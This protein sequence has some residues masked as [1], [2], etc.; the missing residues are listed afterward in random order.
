MAVAPLKGPHATLRSDLWPPLPIFRYNNI[1]SELAECNQVRS[2]IDCALRGLTDRDSSS[3]G[4]TWATR[5][6]DGLVVGFVAEIEQRMSSMPVSVVPSWQLLGVP[7]K[8]PPSSA[9]NLADGAVSA[10]ART[11]GG[12][13]RS[14]SK[15]RTRPTFR[16]RRVHELGQGITLS[17]QNIESIVSRA[18]GYGKLPV[19]VAAAHNETRKRLQRMANKIV[20][21]KQWVGALATSFKMG[22]KSGDQFRADLDQQMS[23][24]CKLASDLSTLKQQIALCGGRHNDLSALEARGGAMSL[25]ATT[26]SSLLEQEIERLKGSIVRHKAAASA[27]RAH[28]I[29][30]ITA[31]AMTQQRPRGEPVN[32][33][34]GRK[35]MQVADRDSEKLRQVVVRKRAAQ[36]TELN[37]LQVTS[38]PGAEV[39][40]PVEGYSK[41]YIAANRWLLRTALAH[42]L[43][44]S[45]TKRVCTGRG[46]IS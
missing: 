32:A 10:I 45:G 23:L 37:E 16:R 28:A 2:E 21:T 30:G 13:T 33:Q 1:H 5:R 43:S 9:T 27:A 19:P 36:F 22:Q 7:N 31:V 38:D 18:E 8:R 35:E 29:A 17:S 15:K 6:K 14:G 25:I 41:L 24:S 40:P 3:S 26:R 12:T 20:E 39:R 42:A 4:A 11:D 34:L 44:S 46:R